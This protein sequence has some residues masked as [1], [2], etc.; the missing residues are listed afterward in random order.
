MKKVLSFLLS[1]VFLHAQT[2]PLFAHRGGPTFDDQVN[3]DIVGTYSG[4]L[5]PDDPVGSGTIADDG[6][7]INSLGLFNVG[8]P[9]TGPATGTFIIF[10]QGYTFTGTMTAVGDPGKGTL[11]GIMDGTYAFTDFVYDA[12]NNPIIGANGP[13]TANYVYIVRGDLNAKVIQAPDF[14]PTSVSSV[15]FSVQRL[16]GTAELG[17]IRPGGTTNKVLHYTIDGVKQSSSV[18]TASVVTTGG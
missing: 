17:V 15:L 6:T 10:T 5:I 4:T 18:A 1:I 12:N 7:A 9:Q 14:D 8:V 16:T 2:A 11:T 3:I 13:L